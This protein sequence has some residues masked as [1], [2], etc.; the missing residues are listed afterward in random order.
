[1]SAPDYEA[2]ELWCD[3]G[4]QGAADDAEEWGDNPMDEG[5]SAAYRSKADRFE[6]LAAA[7]RRAARIEAAARTR[8]A[9]A[10]FPHSIYA[11]DGYDAAVERL[12]WADVELRE[13][14]EA[15]TE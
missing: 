15:D 10:D 8:M 6:R 7:L 12:A 14:L 2:L 3:K 1:M 5:E 4:A 13:A 9:A 11:P